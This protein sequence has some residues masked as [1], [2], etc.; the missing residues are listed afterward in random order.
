M[1]LDTVFAIIAGFAQLITAWL[2]YRVSARPIPPEDKRRH[3]I[4]ES[5]FVVA[6]V[7]GAVTVV[8]NGISLSKALS[9]ITGSQHKIAEGITQVIKNTSQPPVVNMPKLPPTNMARSKGFLQ[10]EPQLLEPKFAANGPLSLNLFFTNKG[11]ESIAGTYHYGAIRVVDDK[12]SPITV[13]SEFLKQAKGEYRKELNSKIPGTTVGGGQAIWNGPL[14]MGC[15]T[16]VPDDDDLSQPGKL[17]LRDCIQP[18][19]APQ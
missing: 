16:Q 17:V 10:L 8:Y 12:E 13:H 3:R 18:T 4:Y 9:N 11:Q 15:V 5:I 6:G 2:G 14:G 19:L 1:E 7:L